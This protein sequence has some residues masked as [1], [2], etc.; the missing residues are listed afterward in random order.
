MWCGK[1]MLLQTVD[2][3]HAA[4]HACFWARW[5]GLAS[6]FGSLASFY[7]GVTLVEIAEWHHICLIYLT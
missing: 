4:V 3:V 5:Y 2:C 7:W 1:L 6:A